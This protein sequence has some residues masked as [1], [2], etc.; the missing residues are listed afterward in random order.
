LSVCVVERRH[1]VGGACVTEE[2]WPGYQVSTAAHV[3]GLLQPQVML[4]LE[5][6]QFGLEII[7][8]PPAVHLL[9]DGEGIVMWPQVE[10]FS[11]ELRR[12]SRKD[13]AAYPS[14]ATHLHQLGPIMRALM[15][16][17]P[18][19]LTPRTWG[20]R[21]DL[22][23]T[24]WNL[25]HAVPR[26]SH[27]YDILTMSAFDYLS[28]WFESDTA[29]IALGYYPAGAAGVST[30]V[31]T[32]GT[33]FLLLRANLRDSTTAAGGTGFV[34]GGMGSITQAILLSGQ[35]FGMEAR[36]G[37]EVTKIVIRSGRARG[38]VLASGEELTSRIVVSNAPARTT[39]L[40]LVDSNVLDP[41]FIA[42][43]RSFGG[44]STAFKI[45]LG[46]DELPD[47]RLRESL[48]LGRGYPVHVII[49]PSIR[50]VEQAYQDVA[51][52]KISHQ[53][54]LTILAPSVLDDNIAPP[55]SHLLDIYG[56]HVPFTPRGTSSW[57]GRRHEI[58]QAAMNVLGAHAPSFS[59]ET[60]REQVLA[61]S[62]FEDV[63][64]LPGGHPHHAD[65]SLD[66]M[67][68]RRPTAGYASYR[69]P[70]DG[71]Y[72]ASASAHPGG[73]V[74]GIPGYNAARSVLA[75]LAY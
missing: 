3:M 12:F 55:G 13:A 36:V 34:R 47:Y 64:G 8:S 57:N 62:D 43:I 69:S 63:F 2:V 52:G 53:P 20:E 71:L 16:S 6:L 35:R 28:R 61:P 65:L 32:P 18:P 22:L 15:W 51:Q 14:F 31:H 38:V 24:L 21:L 68:I 30:S 59:G 25:K 7:P 29:M 70:V 54:Y 9:G 45:H 41:Q 40:N 4:D 56:G 11:A 37:E 67:F 33:A 66:K 5:L 27:I 17:V 74:S 58:K 1:L 39:F 23:R 50:Y 44:V 73:G 72:I 48:E 10:R 19:N 60:E 46:V 75:D 26:V 49:A 42:G